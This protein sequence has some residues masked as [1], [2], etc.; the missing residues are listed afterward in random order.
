M[1]EMYYSHHFPLW[2]PPRGLPWPP[3]R[4][5][6]STPAARSRPASDP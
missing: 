1:N 4:P 3:V 2:L 6:L 5:P